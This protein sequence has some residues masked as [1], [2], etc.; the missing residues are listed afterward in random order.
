MGPLSSQS[1]LGLQPCSLAQG[2]R[3]HPFLGPHTISF[4]NQRK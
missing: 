2:K 1:W 4:S 3:A